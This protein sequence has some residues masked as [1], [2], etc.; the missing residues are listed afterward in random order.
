M[1][2]KFINKK[3]HSK[4]KAKCH[5]KSVDYS[6]KYLGLNHTKTPNYKLKNGI[7]NNNKKEKMMINQPIYNIKTVLNKNNVY[8]NLISKTNKNS[9]T[10][11][12]KKQLSLNK[13]KK[14]SNK[15]N[16]VKLKRDTQ[17]TEYE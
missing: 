14:M 6:S 13:S 7:F 9:Y 4:K 10:I 17:S 11:I 2:K 15:E 1:Y 8:E 12:K 3:N 5:I 16:S